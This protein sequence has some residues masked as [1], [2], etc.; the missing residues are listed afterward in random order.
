MKDIFELRLALEIGMS[1]LIIERHN[2]SDIKELRSIAQKESE[3]PECVVS[4]EVR[5]RYEISFH[6][7][8][9]AMTGNPTLGRFQKM[10][11]P[12]FDFIMNEESNPNTSRSLGN[13]THSDLIDAIELGDA[14]KLRKN[15]REHLT[16]HF[17]QL[18]G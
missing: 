11:L 9:Y 17:S 12:V 5:S 15:M 6:S 3:D 8:L 18:Q 13:I 2:P 7:K 4:H 16:T 14:S 10:L 1:D